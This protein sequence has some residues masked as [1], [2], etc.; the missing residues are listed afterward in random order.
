VELEGTYP[1]PEA[2]IDRFLLKVVVTYPTREEEKKIVARMSSTRPLPAVKQVATS[3]QVFAARELLDEVYVDDKVLTYLVDLAFATRRPAEA[4]LPDLEHLILYGISP[5][6]SIGLT[7]CA[8][9]FAFLE[10]RGFVTPNDI[11][12]VA[13]DVLRHRV[14]ITYEAEAEGITAEKVIQR[15]L[16][17]VKVP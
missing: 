12:S 2:Q 9:A 17:E 1:L 16:D 13:M 5:R 3:E 7:K 4:G 10:G 15:V 6:G 14:I 11:K 8:R